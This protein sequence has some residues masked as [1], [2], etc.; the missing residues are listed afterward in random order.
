VAGPGVA[1]V[2]TPQEPFEAISPGLPCHQ[3]ELVTAHEGRP[4]AEVQDQRHG[5]GRP[6]PDHGLA[7]GPRKYGGSV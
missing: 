3:D 2:S 6:Q 5:A 4:V 7:E 1:A